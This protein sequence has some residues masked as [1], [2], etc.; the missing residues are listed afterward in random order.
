M[1][2]DLKPCPFCGQSVEIEYFVVNYIYC[3]N[4]CGEC[5]KVGEVVENEID[6]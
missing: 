4:D 3:K 2:E 6:N 1:T 5:V